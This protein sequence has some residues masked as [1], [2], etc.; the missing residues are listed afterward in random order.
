MR[1][2]ASRNT[3]NPTAAHIL[4]TCLN[5]PS[6]KVTE[7]QEVGPWRSSRTRCKVGGKSGVCSTI[8]A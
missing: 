5:F 2:R 1:T 7:T 6:F 3:G 8:F 4:R